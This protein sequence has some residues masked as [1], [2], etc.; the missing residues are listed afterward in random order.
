MS[1]QRRTAARQFAAV[2]VGGAAIAALLLGMP[3]AAQDEATLTIPLQEYDDSGV[4][5]TATLEARDGSTQV[6]MM[7]KGEAVTGDHPT[8]IHTGTCTNFDPD[9]TYPLTTV[10]LDNVNNAGVSETTV[11]DVTLRDLLRDDYVI[12]VHQ[13]AE[14]LTNYFVC[15]DIKRSVAVNATPVAGVDEF[16]VAGVGV[17][18]AAGPW[19]TLLGALA[20][21]AAACSVALRVRHGARPL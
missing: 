3:A 1:R 15:G 7:L 9:P 4:S 19:V 2:L 8:H 6:T 13:S 11:E 18:D 17:A 14:D 5:G 10:I 12:L 16:P 20:L 21:L